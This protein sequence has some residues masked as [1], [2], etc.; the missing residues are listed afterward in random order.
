MYSRVRFGDVGSC[1]KGVEVAEMGNRPTHSTDAGAA[2]LHDLV[3]EFEDLSVALVGSWA[4]SRIDKTVST[5]DD[6]MLSSPSS[7]WL[8]QSFP[9]PGA[10]DHGG[11][12]TMER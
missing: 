3:L 2:F 12:R 8:R 9:P 4:D 5:A 6:C 1:C 7:V 10:G 11:T